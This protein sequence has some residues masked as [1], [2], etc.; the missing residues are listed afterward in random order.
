MVKIISKKLSIILI[1]MVIGGLGGMIADRYFFPYLSTTKLFSKYDFLK[2]GTE[3]VTIINK[4][5]QVTM[6]EETSINKITNQVSSSIVNIISYVD[7]AAKISLVKRSALAKEGPR[8]GT[9]IIATSD[10]MIVTYADAINPENSKYKVM[11]YDGNSYDAELVGVDS[12]SNLAFL[13]VS[14]NNLAVASFGDSDAIK[15]GEKI[16]AVS[17]SF[18]SY[19]NK[20]A[21]GLISDFNPSYNLAGL[22]LSSSEKLE[23][24][25]ETDFN[26]REYFIGGPI[27]DYNGQ[28]DGIV[29]VIQ[30]NNAPSYFLIPSNKIKMVIDRVI[31]KEMD[32]NP[33]LGIYYVPITKTFALENNLNM[34]KGAL[35]YSSSGQQGL[36]VLAGSPAQKAGLM[37][38]DVI[39]AVG[40]REISAENSLAD[41]LYQYKKGEQ[42]ELAVLRGGQSLKVTVQL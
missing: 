27:V 1:I 41:L 40:E 36:A 35:I 33:A 8:N 26:S 34:E 9:G 24:V 37:I 17:N 4:T 28:I 20:Y 6:K 15:P 22:S 30:K 31:K 3:D 16:I 13:K 18:G 38:N 39:T 29:G 7:P 21:A 32:L 11:T 25:F 19:A 10:G 5:E 14:A 23:G 42:V 12:Y 2:K